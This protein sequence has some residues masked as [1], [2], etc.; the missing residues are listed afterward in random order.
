MGLVVCHDTGN[1]KARVSL[2]YCPAVV[3]FLAEGAQCKGALQFAF[4]F[5]ERVRQLLPCPQSRGH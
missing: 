1:I 3:A 5:S 4:A 2:A